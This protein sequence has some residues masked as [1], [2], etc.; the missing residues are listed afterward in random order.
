MGSTNTGTQDPLHV[1]ECALRGG[2]TCFQLREKGP[3]AKRGEALL[4][5]ARQCQEL[6]K[7]YG[8]P[9]IVNDDVDL[10]LALDADGVHVGQEDE[11]A[12]IV[13][14]RLGTGK[15]LGVS[16]HTSDEVL[17]AI[18]AGADY[19]GMGPVYTTTSKPDAKPVAGTQFIQTTRSVYPD[20][21]IVGIGG[22]TVD[23]FAPVFAAGANGVSVI[24]AIAG[25]TDVYAAT[26]AFAESIEKEGVP[27]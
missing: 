7:E 2:I 24:S 20:L 18:E 22:I 9:F 10:A 1:L 14:K 15:I 21:P 16:A 4:E 5:F 13:R 17:A 23:N 8:V 11:Q 6:C 25:A 12:A 19:I 27:L 3:G 26:K